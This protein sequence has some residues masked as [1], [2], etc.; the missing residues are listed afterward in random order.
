MHRVISTADVVYHSR[1]FAVTARFRFAMTLVGCD[2]YHLHL[3]DDRLST[4]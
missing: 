3:L 1:L 2:S 4:G